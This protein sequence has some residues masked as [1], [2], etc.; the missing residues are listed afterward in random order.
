MILQK[1]VK[2]Q[3]QRHHTT[4]SR[5]FSVHFRTERTEN[6]KRTGNFLML[7]PR[8]NQWDSPTGPPAARRWWRHFGPTS[9]FW[10]RRKKKVPILMLFLLHPQYQV[11]S[12]FFSFF[13]TWTNRKSGKTFWCC[14]RGPAGWWWR[15]FGPTNR[16]CTWRKKEGA[17]KVRG[18]LVKKCRVISMEISVFGQFFDQ[19]SQMQRVEF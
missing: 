15:C 7:P 5:F 12:C 18:S 14:C 6:Q 13:L 16:F 3:K 9:R 2:T 10:P 4:F 8:Q 17:D 19:K 11:R 1:F